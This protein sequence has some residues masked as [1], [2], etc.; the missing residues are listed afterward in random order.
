MMRSQQYIVAGLLAWIISIVCAR[1]GFSAS[2]IIKISRPAD[3]TLVFSDLQN[4]GATPFRARPLLRSHT[5]R[6]L[7]KRFAMDAGLQRIYVVEL[8]DVM[9]VDDA[10][11]IL[12]ALAQVEYAHPNHV[13]KLHQSPND[14]LFSQ[15]WYLSM[16]D[17]VKAWGTT[18]GTQDVIIGV[19]D[20]G[21]DY[22]HPDLQANIWIN[23][24]EDINH[25]QQ[26]DT[27]DV[28]GVDD[29]GNGYIDDVHGWDFTDAPHF[30]D[31]GD[32]LLRDND[33]FDEHGHGTAV[34]GV[35]AG[36][37][38]NGI[39]I[40]G[41]APKCR[42]MNI[43]A[44]TS[45]GLL[46]EDDVAAAVVYA[47]EM[48]ARVINMSFGDTYASALL[49]DVMQ[50]AHTAGVVLVASAGNSSSD[51]V[52]YPAGYPETISVT[53]INRDGVLAGFANFGPLVD[54]AAPGV[55]VL[56]TGRFGRY[57]NFSGTS[58]AAPV[59]SAV[60]AL[61]LSKSP[62]LIPDLVRS[63]LVSSTNDLGE[64]G[65]D[66]RYASGGINA[67][68]ALAVNYAT[69]AKLMSPRL[70][71]GYAKPPVA[72]IG[73]AAGALLEGYQIDVGVGENPSEFTP[74]LVQYGR[75]VVHDKLGVWDFSDAPDTSYIVRLLA[76]NKDGTQVHAATR[77]FI[78]RTAPIISDV[79]FLPMYDGPDPAMLLSLVTDDYCS[80][81]LQM[82]SR[83]PGS[84]TDIYRFN[85]I[86]VNHQL[87]IHP[88]PMIAYE[89]QLRMTNRSHL[90]SSLE[91]N[92]EALTQLKLSPVSSR[93]IPSAVKSLASGY[94]F[95]HLPDWDGDGVP[96]IILNEWTGGR[97][98][99]NLCF[100][101]FNGQN[102]DSVHT[103]DRLLI[104]RDVGDTD[105]DGLVE[106]LA[107][108]GGMS[109]LLE[110]A[111]PGY[112]PDL[113]IWQDTT[114]AWASRICDLD[115]DGKAELLIK[116]D[117]EFE[118]RE[119]DG[120][121]TYKVMSRISNH[122]TGGNAIGVPHAVIDDFDGDG[123]SE[124]LLADNDGDVYIHEAVGNDRIHETWQDRQPLM[125]SGRFTAAGDFDGDGVSD[126]AVASHS[127]PDIDLE[128]EYDARHWI[129]RIYHSVGDNQYE[130]EWER[131]FFG[132]ND[133]YQASNGLTAADP[134]NDGRAELMLNLFPDFYILDYQPDGSFAIVHHQTPDLSQYN[135][136]GDL[137]ADGAPEYGIDE[138][139]RIRFYR[140]PLSD[141]AS[142]YPVTGLTA[143]P[144]DTSRIWLE[145]RE[146]AG[147]AAYILFRG[148]SVSLLMRYQRI[149]STHVI[150]SSLTQNIPYWY[151]VAADFDTA[152]GQLS[153]PVFAIPNEQ[154]SVSRAEFIDPNQVKLFFSEAM[155]P[156]SIRHC[157]HYNLNLSPI[158]PQSVTLIHGGQGVLLTF[159]MVIAPGSYWINASDVRD[160]LRTPINRERNSVQFFVEKSMPAPY[161][162]SANRSGA[163]TIEL[164]FSQPLEA[165]SAE[166]VSHYRIEPAVPVNRATLST[167]DS[168]LVVLA[169]DHTTQ[170][171]ALGKKYIITVTEVTNR[172]GIPISSLQGNQASLVFFRDDLAQAFTYPNPCN[173]SAGHTG[174]TFAN[175][176]NQAHVTIMNMH[177]T[178]VQELDETDGD[179]GVFW[180]LHDQNGQPVPAG[181][182]LYYI[183]SD[184]DSKQGKC[185]IVR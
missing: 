76:F 60:A 171:A 91:M 166:D 124:L 16:I 154:P 185:A 83:V 69:E 95:P 7:S 5:V 129:V 54:I 81:E 118:L 22:H 98:F 126:F 168:A 13:M 17:V 153:A 68:R 159:P 121:G 99:D 107:G 32:Y 38:G 84:Q 147:A 115:A 119:W 72:I 35:I 63:I 167:E 23:P 67:G 88:Q 122:T 139:D 31:G 138:G 105:E 156:A 180:N 45:Q 101:E 51:V 80:G 125:G 47:V 52:H 85:Y 48:G 90:S 120:N 89:Y 113:I 70:D 175:L 133:L 74:V 146:Q 157:Y 24:D 41:I 62:Q 39:G 12:A 114:D 34:A 53:A 150:D 18:R 14:S 173:P 73:T 93:A 102:W 109:V 40:A 183:T 140:L 127:S 160:A 4:S 143:W 182:Y 161:L 184:H 149:T 132:Y 43:R 20:T 116:T 78:D 71:D 26:F 28:N 10:Q 61:L 2:L 165:V 82:H 49:H 144:L 59:V 44:G 112:Y 134:D 65:W 148:P 155:E 97:G 162:V 56:T 64:P 123:R 141:T 164:R 6:S 96:E 108:S 55:N 100:Y 75:Q 8:P 36:I 128:H 92:Q 137:D 3:T 27:G 66:G 25:N 131:A 178:V 158:N 152:L 110:P 106:L 181:V 179:G 30:P 117:K 94:I 135:L 170:L 37:A 151:A 15:Q 57:G 58:A 103:I 142:D 104:P 29:D 163:W 172:Q 177:G 86:T 50:F 79:D 19:I 77:I 33:P 174:I 145:W 169:L 42:V 111:A 176:T 9:S 21:M 136:I 87:L 1:A 130:V 11:T 46:E